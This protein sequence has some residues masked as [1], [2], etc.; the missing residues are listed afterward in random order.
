MNAGKA[1]R[2]PAAGSPTILELRCDSLASG[3]RAVARLEGRVVFVSGAAP[4]DRI[5]AEITMD[6]GRF[7]EARLVEVLEPSPDRVVPKCAH[8]GDC[9]GCSWQFLSYEAQLAAKKTILADAFRRLGKLE[10]WPEIE[11]VAGEPWGFRNRAQFQPPERS[12]APWG[13]F[14]EGSR[15]TV[16]L[17]ECPVLVPELQGAWNDLAGSKANPWDDRRQRTAFAWGADGKRWMR[18]PGEREGEPAQAQV[19]GRAL[20]FTVDGFFQ[21]NLALVPRMVELV[22]DGTSGSEAWDLY[23]GVGLFASHLETRFDVVHAVENDPSA[24][25]WA[26]S[27]LTRSIYHDEPV[28]RWLAAR[29]EAGCI[30][31][32]LVVVDPPREGLSG[33]ALE[34]LVACQPGSIRYVS[35]GHDTL[36]RDLRQILS[37]GYLLDKVVLIDLYPHTPHLE[38]VSYLRK[39]S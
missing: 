15:R 27:N 34:R 37:N 25:R 31:P 22:V 33:I 12:G 32:D 39:R 36:A 13:F 9:G 30:R 23:A 8:F 28:E 4:G 20:R 24:A 10:S 7:L 19:M 1:K 35:C 14:A 17:R 3:G 38:V 11:I 16:E 18:R 29:L 21:S 26:P 6:K 2:L 5:L